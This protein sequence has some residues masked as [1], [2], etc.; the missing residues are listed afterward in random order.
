V[1]EKPLTLLRILRVIAF[2]RAS[3]RGTKQSLRQCNNANIFTGLLVLLL[4]ERYLTTVSGSHFSFL[5]K[6]K[7]TKRKVAATFWTYVR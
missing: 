7:V 3:M 4:L 2:L 1:E 6:E 5:S